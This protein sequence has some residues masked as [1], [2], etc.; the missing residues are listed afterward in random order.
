MSKF[1]T[2]S[3]SSKL[4]SVNGELRLLSAE[5]GWKREV[6]LWLLNDVTNRNNWRY[7]NLEEHRKKFA[8]TPILIAYR[9]GEIGDGHNFDEIRDS[10]GEILESFMSATAERI[11]G[12]IEKDEDVRIEM[13][14]GK[15]W[16]VAKAYIWKWYARELVKKLEKQGLQGMS[17]SIE[18]LI[19]EMYK[20]GTTEIFTKYQVLGTTILGDDI[21][22]AVADATIRVLSA[23]GTEKVKKMTLRVASENS[24]N[25]KNPQQNKKGVKESMKIKE[26]AEK[27]PSYSVL[28]VENS[29]VV[30]LSDKGVASIS[31]IEKDGE[32]TI[33]GA[34]NECSAVATFG[35]GDSV[36]NVSV[37]TI[38]EALNQ[39]KQALA[40]KLATAEEQRDAALKALGK[41]QETE[42][43]RR[44]K[45]VKEAITRRI[46]EIEQS[47]KVD[48]SDCED[49][50]SDES[51]A[52]YAE[53]EE[54]E[55]FCGDKA[56]CKDVDARA[57]DKILS[58]NTKKNSFAWEFEKNQDSHKDA[59]DSAID[60][61]MK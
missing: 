50:L 38:F 43:S 17:V 3:D 48:M 12:Y 37:E 8:G 5:K 13:R 56:A 42:K 35:D 47:A 25:Q 26:I 52:I 58:S 59:L 4:V 18:T 11:V 9:N 22:P 33:V 40:Q 51:V 55:E 21:S 32:D 19:D 44:Q 7:I 41:M 15:K 49:L 14:D 39:K 23:I 27:F 61:I 24:G 45:A 53:M 2:I 10:D 31:S 6:E 16:I 60:N 36:I 46:E 30:M 28:A 34:R 54:D 20:E 57:M 1:K 29:K